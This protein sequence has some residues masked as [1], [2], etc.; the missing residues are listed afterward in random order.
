MLKVVI[1][2]N[3]AVS[4]LLSPCGNSAQ[5]IDKIFDEDL[6]PFYCDKILAEYSM[7]LARP[8]FRFSVEDQANVIEGIKKYGVVV[9]P[10][11]CDI[12]FPDESD[13]VFYEVAKSADA[14]LVTG[15]AK[16]YLPEPFI[17]NPAECIDLLNKSKKG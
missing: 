12:P 9:E 13:R 2:T 8:R 5:I 1:D 11:P 14:Y 6:K 3:V 7:V 16:H 15:N 10:S 4:A 17:I